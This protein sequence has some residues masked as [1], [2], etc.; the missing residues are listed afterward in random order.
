MIFRILLASFVAVGLVACSDDYSSTVNRV[1][2]KMN[3]RVLKEADPDSDVP[4]D[5]TVLCI[6]GVK[7]LQ[8]KQGGITVKYQANEQGDPS[9]EECE[10]K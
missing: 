10:L 2:Q 3:V 1:K 9:A 8:T 5:F 7:Y 6:D 4:T